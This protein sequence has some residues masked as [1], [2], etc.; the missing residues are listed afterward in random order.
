MLKDAQNEY[1]TALIS[2]SKRNPKVLF[3]SINP[4]YLLF[5]HTYPFSQ[6]RTEMPFSITLWTKYKMFEQALHIHLGFLLVAHNTVQ[7][8]ILFLQFP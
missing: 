2:S 3:D 1:F 7:I 4:L 6:M 8:W 5:L